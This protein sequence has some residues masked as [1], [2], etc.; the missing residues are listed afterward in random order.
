MWRFSG[1]F[2]SSKAGLVM[3]VFVESVYMSD[4]EFARHGEFEFKDGKLINKFHGTALTFDGDWGVLMEEE[5]NN[6]NQL[7]EIVAPQGK[8]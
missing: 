5:T 6:T 2:L 7:W 3:D 4:K 8:I 1:D